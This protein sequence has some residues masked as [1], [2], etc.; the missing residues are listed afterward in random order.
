SPAAARAQRAP[1]TTPVQVLSINPLG[2]I[3]PFFS[4]E[5]EYALS[6][7]SSGAVTASYYNEGNSNSRDFRHYSLDAKYRLFPGE[8]A[9][10]GFSVG[11]TAGFTYVHDADASCSPTDDC[12]NEKRNGAALSTGL[13]VN[14]GWLFG[15]RREFAVGVGVG[16]KRL[17]FLGDRP[18]G[19]DR[20]EP[21]LRL[22]VG[23]AF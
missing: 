17:Y 20:V 9:P 7:T 16:A 11:I 3:L 4:I 18:S 2:L 6:P 10:A 5:Y 23:K 1:V 15:S 13:E 21:T 14:H 22:S 12:A 8:Q 19:V